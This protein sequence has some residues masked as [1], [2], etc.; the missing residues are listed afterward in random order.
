M[1]LIIAGSRTLNPEWQL[2]DALV[3][4]F[5]MDTITEVVSGGAKG[6][7]TDAQ[8]WAEAVKLPFKLFSADWETHG[9]SAG[10]KRNAE[11]AKYGDALLAIWDGHSRGTNNMIEVMRIYNKPVYITILRTLGVEEKKPILRQG[12]LKVSR[13]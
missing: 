2:I 5:D 12:I 7:D 4:Q 3:M 6:V 11:M 13:D 1:K 8:R 10:Y 9:K